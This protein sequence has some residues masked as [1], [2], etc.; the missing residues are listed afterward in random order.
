MRGKRRR[1]QRAWFK[2][3]RDRIGRDL[4]DELEFYFEQSIKDLEAQG[5][6]PKAAT[7]ETRRRF[8]DLNSYRRKLEHIDRNRAAETMS[9]G[10]TRVL[11][12]MQD[13]R[14]GARVLAQHPSFTLAAVVSLALGIGVN[15]AIFSI[16]N[17]LLDRSFNVAA[18]EQ[19]VAVFTSRVGGQAHGNTS[20]PDYLD[21]KQQN[22]VFSDLAAHMYAPMA[23][24]AADAPVIMWGQ[25]VSWDYFAMLGVEPMVGR[26]FLPG[27]DDM[28]A[29]AAVAV[30]SYGTWQDLFG[31][32]ADV[33]G[34]TVRVND[35]PFTV[36]GVAPP[37]FT[38]LVSIVEPAL[39]A[40]LGA[41]DYALPYTPNVPSRGD[42]W[43][44][45]VGR[46]EP[47][48]TID[49]AQSSLDVLAAN[50]TATYPVAN[51]GKGIAIA[52][53]DRGRLG[54]PEATAGV[55]NLLT[56]LMAVVGFVLL[57][58]CLNVANLQ[59]AKASAR[60]REIA[61][62]Y[63]LGASRWRVARQLLTESV[64]LALVAGAVGLS[65]AVVAVDALQALQPQTVIP[66]DI[67][68]G[69]DTRV[70]GFTLLVALST[71][72]LFGLVPVLQVLRAGQIEALRDQGFALG[73]SRRKSHL[74]DSFVAAQVALSLVLL[75][76]AGLFVRSLNNTL[77]IDP[78][79]D[80][81]QGVIIPLNL[82]Y[83]QY[84]EA[85]GT[86]LRQRLLDRIAALPGVESAALSAFLPLGLVHGHHDVFV[87][88]YEPA[89]NEFMLVK[90]NLVSPRYFET[91]GIR[92]LRGRAIDERDVEDAQ[93]VAMINETM[94]RRFWPDRDPLGRTV[95]ADLGITYTVVG[96]IADGKYGSLREPPQPYLVIP[97]KQGEYVEMVNL[98]VKT[99]GDAA[100]M[101]GPLS[102]EV[103]RQAPSV[104]QSSVLTMPQYLQYSVGDAKTPTILVS[105]FGVLATVLAM[106]GL[107]GVM[108][109]TVSRRTRELG[110]RLALGATRNGVVRMVLSRGLQTTLIGIG[111]GVVLAWAF[112]R[113][114]SGFLYGVSTLDPLVFTLA[115]AALLTIGLL[116]SYRPARTAARV[117][118]V[119]VLR[120]E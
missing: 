102:A 77:A 7:D 3:D 53:L 47:G 72:V 4:D 100:A 94:A 74:Q 81:R 63:S 29:P 68:V 17:S 90:R 40:P 88:G 21:Y 18:P 52:E 62:R 75:A 93:P 104:P 76:A 82:G 111:V 92:V 34:R 10:W 108:S 9:R 22:E 59:L 56:V 48:V 23:V 73:R 6:S 14:H 30:L 113:V 114:L 24:G 70:L 49:Q 50:L 36:I 112:T 67:Q 27:E 20:Y 69:L 95:R 83:T 79:F 97:L 71:G 109:Y 107:Y 85:E 25:L 28:L 106:V 91:M 115:A 80:L 110:V 2:D 13:I 38:G 15:T 42:P 55:E 64:L 116:A 37:G 58:A 41:A 43:L 118:P 31:A 39:W 16:V 33:V 45:L 98:V 96:I 32:D 78:G 66:F 89:P 44:Q 84:D 35:H 105:A 5:F 60:R 57:I 120:V 86:E 99:A 101:V 11:G 46:L 51:A 12:V 61:L 1:R 54:S 103:R 119:E 117:D 65:L 87:E 8:G 26:G 19:L